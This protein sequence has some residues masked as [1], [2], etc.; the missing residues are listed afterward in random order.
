V[1]DRA[2]VHPRPLAFDGIFLRMT[3]EQYL[4]DATGHRS[5]VV[6]DINRYT[7]LI[8]AEEE[9]SAIRAYDDAKA[10][11]DEVIPFETAVAEIEIGQR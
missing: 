6:L 11:H 3:N 8:E 2:A 4:V 10:A 9:L 7:E 5:A 1:L